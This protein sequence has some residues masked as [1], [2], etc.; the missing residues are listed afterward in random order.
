MS[1]LLVAKELIYAHLNQPRNSGNWTL[2]DHSRRVCQH[3]AHYVDDEEVII[4]ACLHDILEDST[5]SESDLISWWFS[6]YCVDLILWCSYDL[7]LTT[8]TEQND[9]LYKKLKQIK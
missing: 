4:A 5:V 2:A 7:H 8:K 1:S 6:R 3:T 9:S